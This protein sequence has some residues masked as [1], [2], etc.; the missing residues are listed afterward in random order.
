MSRPQHDG[1]H[2]TAPTPKEADF[3]ARCF[4]LRDVME[5]AVSIK[6]VAEDVELRLLG[7][8]TDERPVAEVF[9]TTNVPCLVSE[10][11]DLT[12]QLRE[13]LF[14]VSDSVNRIQN[15][16][17]MIADRGHT[18]KAPVDGR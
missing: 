5:L 13:E 16:L 9:G 1:P 3:A 8:R 18:S 2:S 14:Q 15:E 7:E 11:R 6:G 4:D 12:R 17:G 10:F